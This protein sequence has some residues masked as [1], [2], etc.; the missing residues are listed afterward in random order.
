MEVQPSRLTLLAILSVGLV[1]AVIV[2]P[3][4]S[5]SAFSSPAQPAWDPGSDDVLQVP[6]GFC[7][8][9]ICNEY[10]GEN[11]TTCPQDCGPPPTAVSATEAADEELPT[12][13]PRALVRAAQTPRP[14]LVA[15]ASPTP[16]ITPTPTSLP[17][18]TPGPTATPTGLPTYTPTVD[19][20]HPPGCGLV[21]Y[22]SR[23]EGWKQAYA[24]R[25][26][27][28]YPVP[29]R[30][31]DLEVYVCEAPPIGRLCFLLYDGLLDAAQG[32]TDRIQLVDC[33]DDACVPLRRLGQKVGEQFCFDITSSDDLTC[34]VG[35]AMVLLAPGQSAAGGPL[36]QISPIVF[37]TGGCLLAALFLILLL[38]LLA[39]R[40]RRDQE[41][42]EAQPALP[43]EEP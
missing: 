8:D 14:T 12:S 23:P 37:V 33:S 17:T 32:N 40:R 25:A 15:T 43:G 35:C 29:T 28:T 26:V 41:D 19:V 38:F 6:G 3:A 4:T 16:T 9:L 42:E 31:D 2:A 18:R 13:T 10:A 20:L 24:E 11:S 22:E 39:R 21:S 30:S 36:R 34:E 27:S 5:V 1:L 7:G